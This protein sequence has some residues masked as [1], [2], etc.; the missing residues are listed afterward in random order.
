MKFI[1]RIYFKVNVVHNYNKFTTYLINFTMVDLCKIF[2]VLIMRYLTN[3]QVKK[4]Q[5]FFL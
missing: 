1:C 2:K 3:N 4:H 5:G